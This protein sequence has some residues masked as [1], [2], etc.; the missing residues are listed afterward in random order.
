[1]KVSHSQ[2]GKNAKGE[3]VAE[4]LPQLRRSSGVKEQS[5]PILKK[6]SDRTRRGLWPRDFM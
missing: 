6:P 5:P 3:I 2:T 1:M 4:S